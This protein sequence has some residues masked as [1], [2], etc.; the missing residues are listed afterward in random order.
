MVVGLYSILTTRSR[1][2]APADGDDDF[3]AVAGGELRGRML[4]FRDDFAVAFDGDA[5][6][7]IA[8]LLDQAGDGQRFGKLAG[9]A[10]DREFHDRAILPSCRFFNAL[11]PA[12]FPK[13]AGSMPNK[14]GRSAAGERAERPPLTLSRH[15]IAARGGPA[16]SSLTA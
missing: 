1:I 10:V 9:S 15:G 5:L 6:A 3:E 8:E 2:L 16:Q 14:A 12:D 11:E 13:S 7:G 4:T